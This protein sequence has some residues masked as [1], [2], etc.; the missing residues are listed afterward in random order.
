MCGERMKLTVLSQAKILFSSCNFLWFLSV[1]MVW[2]LWLFLLSYSP[3]PF[4]LL[5]PQLCP[6]ALVLPCALAPLG[7]GWC[8]WSV[9]GAAWFAGDSMAA[10]SVVYD[11]GNRASQTLC[12]TQTVQWA[13][14]VPQWNTSS[15]RVMCHAS[16][17][18]LM[19]FTQSSECSSFSDVKWVSAG[20]CLTKGCQEFAVLHWGQNPKHSYS[21]TWCGHIFI[22]KSSL[23]VELLSLK[24]ST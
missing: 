9:P 16:L 19:D 7:C 3:L 6:R 13:D 12:F 11:P 10:V 8:L 15:W 17:V 23:S 5:A 24:L 18:L 14:K 21:Q 2:H 20:H 4:L 22:W 1:S